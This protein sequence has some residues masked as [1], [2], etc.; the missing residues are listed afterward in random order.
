MGD[1]QASLLA[2]G[3]YERGTCKA[4]FGSG[5]SILM[6]TGDRFESSNRGAVS[7]LAWVWQGQPTYALEGIINYSSATIAWL[8]DQ[9]GLIADAVGNC[10]PCPSRDG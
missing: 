6:N 9:L 7:A 5:T 1:S 3:C 2:Q 8:K 4:T 10:G